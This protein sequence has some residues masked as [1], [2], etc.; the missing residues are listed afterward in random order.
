[1]FQDYLFPFMLGMAD[2]VLTT[3]FPQFMRFIQK[4]AMDVKAWRESMFGYLHNPHS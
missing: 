4:R 2:H 3:Y 1:M